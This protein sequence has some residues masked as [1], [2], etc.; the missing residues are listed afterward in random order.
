MHTFLCLLTPFI[1]IEL[2]CFVHRKW[3]VATNDNSPME[4]ET[5]V[6]QDIILVNIRLETL[7]VHRTITNHKL[8]I[9]I[10]KIENNSMLT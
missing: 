8:F 7:D 10:N 4:V 3:V 1:S 2:T 9:V 6:E 5:V